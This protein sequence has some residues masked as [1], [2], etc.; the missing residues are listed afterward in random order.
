[1][2][3]L[4]GYDRRVGHR[5]C[6]IEATMDPFHLNLVRSALTKLLSHPARLGLSFGA[7]A[8]AHSFVEIARLRS[9]IDSVLP[10]LALQHA[11]QV[12]R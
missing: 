2:V 9:S 10:N 12:V 7:D 8:M 5:C 1:M 11:P 4:G 6:L 3:I